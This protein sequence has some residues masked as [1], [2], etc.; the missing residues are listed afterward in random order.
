MGIIS[1]SPQE[2]Q[3]AKENSEE[4]DKKSPK[5]KK[6]PKTGL[7]KKNKQKTS[8]YNNHI[9]PR[10]KSKTINVNTA[11]KIFTNKILK[12][13]NPV[14]NKNTLSTKRPHSKEKP[15]ININKEIKSII[16]QN[17]KRKAVSQDNKK[18]KEKNLKKYNIN[19]NH[20]SKDLE[21]DDFDI[22]IND[23]DF[24]DESVQVISPEIIKNN[25]VNNKNILKEKIN[26][27]KKKIINLRKK[28]NTE[29]NNSAKEI[30]INKIK[31]DINNN[32]EINN[33]SIKA[34]KISSTIFINNSNITINNNN[35]ERNL[36]KKKFIKK[37]N[38]NSALVE[39][40]YS[41]INSNFESMD[42]DNIL[43]NVFA[44]KISTS[45]IPKINTQFYYTESNFNINHTKPLSR[46][47]QKDYS[48]LSLSKYNANTVNKKDKKTMIN[49]IEKLKEK[50][51]N[52][53]TPKIRK[54]F[55]LFNKKT[56]QAHH[57]IKKSETIDNRHIKNNI[58][59]YRRSYSKSNHIFISTLNSIFENW[60]KKEKND[61]TLKNKNTKISYNFSFRRKE[62]KNKNQSQTETKKIQV[63]I[64]NNNNSN[65]SSLSISTNDIKIKNKILYNLITKNI[66]KPDKNNKSFDI[67]NDINNSD[68]NINEIDKILL[69]K[70]RDAIDID[71]SSINLKDSLINKD[72]IKSNINN[73]III[74]YSKL[75]S[76]SISQ[77]LF[78]GIIYKVVD[79][80]F[81]KKL[82][83]ME[84][85]FQLK[86]N[87]FRYF[88]NIQMARYNEEKPLVQFDIRH[89]KSLN[90]IDN[91]IFD[92]YDLNGKNIEFCFSVFL[93][94][95]SDFFVFVTYNKNFGNSLFGLM[96]LLK[97]YYEDKN[98]SNI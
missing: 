66:I 16:F 96:S 7:K 93:N 51:K 71:I 35:T 57:Q 72:L 23:D 85:Y 13:K 44:N 52:K 59:N 80:Y 18:N 70:Y 1:C 69:T 64:N 37:K 45:S 84:R 86:K 21:D 26:N 49:K 29:I 56:F 78:D 54:T 89:I 63:N 60:D 43:E 33:N 98:S 67:N 77:I 95:N 46:L 74:N 97:N 17:K 94:Q 27:T 10:L 92:E 20:F 76:I 30:N 81:G 50:I 24:L 31:N 14:Y 32:N 6:D 90:I 41:M 62:H 9:N 12:T 5:V 4:I 11:K 88:N 53:N 55:P 8:K 58:P 3:R 42:I 73:K 2:N 82:K 83:I 28:L 39:N 68:N 15:K 34:N 75:E 22:I 65:N 48:N 19:Y 79:N 47:F 91:K 87:C 38:N 25:K 40:S 61:K 36:R